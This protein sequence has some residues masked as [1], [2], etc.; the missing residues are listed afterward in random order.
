[1][2]VTSKG[3]VTIP[4]AIRETLGIEP[5]GEVDFIAVGNSIRL[6]AAN[7]RKF[8]ATAFR[9]VLDSVAGTLDLSST[10]TD[11]YMLWLRGPRDD[12]NAD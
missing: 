1:M 2:R 3:Q 7:E 11:D 10:T 12:L 9:Q 4:K 8:D 6:V 5:G